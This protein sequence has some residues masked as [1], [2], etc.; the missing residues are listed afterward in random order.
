MNIRRDYHISE[1]YG[2]SESGVAQI[3]QHLPGFTP[4][5]W[6]AAPKQLILRTL[7]GIDRDYGS[8]PQYL[9]SIGFDDAWQ[10]KLVAAFR[11]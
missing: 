10:R 4:A 7:Q 5:T 11:V 9:T 2:L 1:A 3:K 8:V 6:G